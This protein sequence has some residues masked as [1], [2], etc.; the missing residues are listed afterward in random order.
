MVIVAGFQY[1]YIIIE[2]E[3]CPRKDGMIDILQVL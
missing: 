1:N 2:P 3:I